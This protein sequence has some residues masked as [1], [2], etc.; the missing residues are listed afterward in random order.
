MA[1]D[2]DGNIIIACPNYGDMSKPAVFM[3]LDKEN[4]VIHLGEDPEWRKSVTADKNAMRRSPE[5][6]VDGKFIHPHDA[7][8]APNGDIYVAE[9]VATGRISKLRKV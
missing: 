6:W 8:F 5:A 4:K 7:C 9:W 1:M 2:K 3:K